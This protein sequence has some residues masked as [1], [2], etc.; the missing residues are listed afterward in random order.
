MIRGKAQRGKGKEQRALAI[1]F[2]LTPYLFALCSSP[3]CSLPDADV[4]LIRS[5]GRRYQLDLA[6]DRILRPHFVHAESGS[7]TLQS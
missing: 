7:R 4:I 6:M 1:P 5:N 3:F 2:A